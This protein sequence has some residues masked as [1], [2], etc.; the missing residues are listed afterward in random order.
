MKTPSLNYITSR[1]IRDLAILAGL[2]LLMP[3]TAKTA[4]LATFTANNTTI[5]V[6]GSDSI[7]TAA[8]TVGGTGF[9]GT[10]LQISGGGL[11]T[12]TGASLAFNVG[13]SG[14]T[15]NSFSV[16]GST[17][18]ASNSTFSMVGTGSTMTVSNGGSVTAGNNGAQLNTGSAV[19]ITGINSKW[20]VGGININSGNSNSVSVLAG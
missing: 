12:Q 19:T 6:T 7:S 4:E 15:G 16:N 9:S 18:T 10:S 2:A 5:S 3:L 13:V 8:Y 17:F 20:T 11:L 14:Q 1:A